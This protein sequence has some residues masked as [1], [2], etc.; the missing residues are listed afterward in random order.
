M[1]ASRA[2]VTTQT[3]KAETEESRHETQQL[4][5]RFTDEAAE[6]DPDDP[7][8]G[9]LKQTTDEKESEFQVDRPWKHQYESDVPVFVQSS[10]VPRRLISDW[11]H[12]AIHKTAI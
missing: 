10:S 11:H 6:R 5:R 12:T 7:L 1:A 4:I 2:V 8:V 9:C 3:P